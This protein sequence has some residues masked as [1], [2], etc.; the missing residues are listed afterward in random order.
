[1][2][3]EAWVNPSA[4]ANWRTVAIKEAAA[5]LSYSLYA[6]DTSSKPSGWI[7]R[8]ADVGATGRSA[9]AL[10]TWVHLATTYDGTRLLTYVNGAQVA[11]TSVT[12]SIVTST[13]PL[14]I[15]GNAIWGE[16]FSGKIDELRIYNRALTAAQ[17]Q[18]D[19]VT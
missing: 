16:F 9:I 13:Q 17:I 5:G 6:S 2:T 18:T 8:S 4:L 1:M 14:R 12:G 19:M 3:V 7:R 11:S 10:N 15:G